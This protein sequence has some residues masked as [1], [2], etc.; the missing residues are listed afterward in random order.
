MAG[1]AERRKGREAGDTAHARRILS[2]ALKLGKDDRG[3][4]EQI[5]LLGD[6]A[7]KWI[8]D[9]AEEELVLLP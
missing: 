9:A 7:G 3:P 6:K 8:A 4:P 5:V 1:G 2:A